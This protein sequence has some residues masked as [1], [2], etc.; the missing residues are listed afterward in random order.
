MA[1][2]PASLRHVTDES[3][4]FQES[5]LRFLSVWGD[6]GPDGRRGTRRDS[7]RLGCLDAAARTRAEM[8]SLLLERIC[9]A[10]TESVAT[11]GFDGLSMED[12]ALR[13][14]CSRATVYRRVGGKEA[15]RD[16]V[17]HQAVARLTSSVAQAVDHLDGQERLVAVI[18]A[19]VDTIRADPVSA[20]LLTGTAAAH[21]VDSTVISSFTDSV[22]HLTGIRSDDTVAC[23]L[24]ARVTLALLCWPVADRHTETAI[25]RRFVSSAARV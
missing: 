5:A 1:S 15:I 25:I 2:A 3:Q 14:G 7:R 21:S 19:S 6:T 4:A 17:L 23:E 20:A 13:A 11:N 18:V 24:L 16:V 12:I 9:I 8:S 22:A 10:A